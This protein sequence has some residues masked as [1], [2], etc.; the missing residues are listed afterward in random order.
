MRAKLC[1]RHADINF[2]DNEN[3]LAVNY[4]NRN[5]LYTKSDA[6]VS[7]RQPTVFNDEFLRI[8]FLRF[9][10]NAKFRIKP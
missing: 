1:E 2:N 4:I 6:G 10:E 3:I 5:Q 9:I 7:V 8:S